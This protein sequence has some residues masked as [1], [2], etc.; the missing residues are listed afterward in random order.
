MLDHGRLLDQDVF[1][2][3]RTGATYQTGQWLGEV[4]LAFVYRQASWLGVDLLR[5]VLVGAAVFFVARATARVQPHIGWA[6]VPILATI[7]VSRTI[8]G[9]RP[10]LFTLALVPAVF[11]LLLA[12]R[13]ER[14]PRLLWILP[15]LFVLW[16][17]LHGAFAIGLV[18]V[19]VFAIEAVLVRES[20]LR[21]P[22]VLALA[23]CVVMTPFLAAGIPAVLGRRPL[24]PVALPR[25]IVVAAC[26]L[27]ALAV[28]TVAAVAAPRAPDLAAYPAD[29]LDALATA[30]GNL[31]NEYDWGGYLIFAS[32]SHPL[33]ID[34]RRAT[35]FLPGVLDAFEEAVR[36]HRHV[37][38]DHR[39]PSGPARP[40]ARRRP[41]RARVRGG[42]VARGDRAPRARG[43][44][45]RDARRRCRA[46]GASGPSPPG[47][48]RGA[49]GDHALALRV[50][51]PSAA[52]GVRPLR[53]ADLAAPGRTEGIVAGARRDR[54][55]PRP[56][57]ESPRIERARTRPHPHRARGARAARWRLPPH[58]RAARGGRALRDAP[59]ACGLRIVGLV[60]RSLP[61]AAALHRGG[62]RAEPA[63]RTGPHLRPCPRAR[64]GDRVPRSRRAPRG[65]RAPA[66]GRV[67][68]A[69][70]G[71][72]HAVLR[73]RGGPVSRGGGTGGARVAR[74]AR[75]HLGPRPRRFA[76]AVLVAGRRRR[77]RRAGG[78]APPP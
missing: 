60:G 5:A 29:A 76:G 75:R 62:G 15:P 65:G 18:L 45:A 71:A 41:H 31:L 40:M 44:P 20:A 64:P 37:R 1:S 46:R 61:R 55:A 6:A 57:V 2:F 78:A 9:D 52:R 21:R 23:A 77:R 4:V 72:P 42:V 43:R 63:Q 38:L 12:V 27:F 25:A 8:W 30:H 35:L 51:R 10:Q 67:R 33:F 17:N 24:A 16:G 66:A 59:H 54:P 48:P 69:H 47:A 14:R 26:A 32:P 68:L 58:R 3:T 74:A 13:L 36:P 34:G 50:R 73:D 22:L 7:L 56:L 39:G 11:D 53:R 28:A 49:A 70:R 19:T